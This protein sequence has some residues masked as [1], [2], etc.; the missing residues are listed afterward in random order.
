[1]EGCTPGRFGLLTVRRTHR[2]CRSGERSG[3]PRRHARR[4][5]GADYSVPPGLVRRRVQIRLSPQ[6]VRIFLEGRLIAL[7]RR[8]YVP[9]DCVLDPEHARA[10]IAA[11]EARACSG[12]KTCL[13]YTS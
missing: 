11:R 8:S 9:A 13:L 4:V 3:E 2:A 10:L 5:A 12:S 7:H 6:E 1:M